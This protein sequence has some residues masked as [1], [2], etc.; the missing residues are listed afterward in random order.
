MLSCLKSCRLTVRKFNINRLKHSCFLE[1]FMKIDRCLLE[2]LETSTSAKTS[3]KLALYISKLWQNLMQV[4]DKICSSV[5][6]S[7][8][9]N[10]LT[11]VP[12][13]IF[14]LTFRQTFWRPSDQNLHALFLQYWSDP[15]V[16]KSKT[17]NLMYS[18]LSANV[19]S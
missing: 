18:N 3:F 5:Y 19:F 8:V 13:R 10:C 12:H 9:I 4:M 2:Y 14:P 6:V 16:I 17:G 7:K 11:I 15:N 1:D